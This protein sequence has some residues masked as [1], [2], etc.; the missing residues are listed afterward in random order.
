MNKNLTTV[1]LGVM[2]IVVMAAPAQ[3]RADEIV[4]VMGA[5]AAA[6]TKDQV[7][8]IYLGRNNNLSPVDL[9]ESNPLRAAFYKKATDRD[10]PQIKAVWSH[11]T[12][13]GQGQPPKEMPDAAAIKKAVAANPK[14]VGYI[15]K[16]DVDASVKVVLTL[17]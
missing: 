4:V 16:A 17:N 11:L 15:D 8:G 5:G 6:L 1:L 14:A 2:A 13:T 12:F 3:A 10:P 7:A 9:P